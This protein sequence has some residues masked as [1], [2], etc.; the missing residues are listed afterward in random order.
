MILRY[1][2][3][4]D[5]FN[6]NTFIYFSE[7]NGI[8]SKYYYSKISKSYKEISKAQKLLEKNK[9]FMSELYS[10]SR[11]TRFF[12]KPLCQP[13]PN[14]LPVIP[15]ENDKFKPMIQKHFL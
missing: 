13:S 9:E 15:F 6:F 4:F 5:I 14:V 3:Y 11:A 12:S 10:F 1:Y 2:Y 8:I 7:R